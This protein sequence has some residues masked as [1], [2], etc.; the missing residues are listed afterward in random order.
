[1][2]QKGAVPVERPK[3][4]T[5]NVV[6]DCPEEGPHAGILAGFYSNLLG[7]KWTHPRANGWAAI[8]APT[9]TVIA[10]Q[11]VEEYQPPV[12]PGQPGKQGQ[13]L[14][15]D[16]WVENL[17]EGVAFALQCGA[18]LAMQQYFTTSKT[19]LDPAGHPF[20]IDTEGE[21]PG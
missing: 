10:F 1:M 6:I 12:W 9:G 2:K 17:E 15:L 20:C 3:I 16:I 13:M 4:L 5:I 7:W 18:T 21:E 19:L 11:E 8:T 14:H